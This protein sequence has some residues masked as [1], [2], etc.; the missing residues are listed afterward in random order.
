MG[1][2]SS[3]GYLGAM[4]RTA[5]ELLA[6]VNDGYKPFIYGLPYAGATLSVARGG[7][8]HRLRCKGVSV[9]DHPH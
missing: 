3:T 6:P 5:D 4:G 8:I 7:K 1:S 9:P 2:Y